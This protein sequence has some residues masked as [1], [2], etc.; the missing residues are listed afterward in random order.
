MGLLSSLGSIGSPTARGASSH[1]WAAV[2]L[3]LVCL[4]NIVCAI[5]I[6]RWRR[7]GYFGLIATALVAFAI[8]LAYMTRPVF[9]FLGLLA[10]LLLW[11]L[12]HLGGERNAWRRMQ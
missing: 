12:L 9:A 8:N 5:A 3:A 2:T 6:I 7:W 4:A 10:P 1:T 11:G